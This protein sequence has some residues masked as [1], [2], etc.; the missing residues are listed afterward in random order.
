MRRLLHRAV[1]EVEPREG[2]LEQLRRAVPARRAR[3]RQAAVGMA[4]AA[5][6]IGTA[7][8]ALLHVSDA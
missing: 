1:E 4:A 6:L 2:A 8:P 5:L 7:V 3:K